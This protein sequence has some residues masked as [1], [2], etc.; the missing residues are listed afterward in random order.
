MNNTLDEK[1]AEIHFVIDDTAPQVVIEGIDSNEIY[2]SKQQNVNVMVDDNFKLKEAW[3]YL[4][5]EDGEETGRWN[6][7][8][9]AK[10]SGEVVTI[11]VPGSDSKQTFLY[12]A[13]DAAG[14]EVTALPDSEKVPK[15]FLITTNKWKRLENSKPARAVAASAAILGAIA[16]AVAVL[17]R[18]LKK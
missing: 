17:K 12:S 13:C 1:G 11:T 3:F 10:Q 16:A 2:A 4:V 14:N 9:L 7:M 6:Y 15:D 8:E 18:K 5:N